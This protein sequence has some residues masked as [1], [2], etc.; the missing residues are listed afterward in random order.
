MPDIVIEDPMRH[1]KGVIFVQSHEYHDNP[2]AK[3]KDQYQMNILKK[4]NWRVFPIYN[5]EIDLL[6]HANRCFLVLGIY[7]AMK[8][9]RMYLRAFEGE[10]EMTH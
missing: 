6:H 2:K 1:G 7:A 9:L 8:D 10:K 4:N 5:E 3:K